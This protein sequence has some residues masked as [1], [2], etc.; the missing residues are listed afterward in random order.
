MRAKS[1]LKSE[2]AID[3]EIKSFR[4]ILRLF[5]VRN[6]ILRSFIPQQEDPA[7]LWFGE[8]TKPDDVPGFLRYYSRLHHDVRKRNQ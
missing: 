8:P 6:T 5:G 2:P 7:E 4:R 1:N 3:N